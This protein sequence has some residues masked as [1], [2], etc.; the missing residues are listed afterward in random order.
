MLLVL[1]RL[2]CRSLSAHKTISTASNHGRPWL[3]LNNVKAASTE[4]SL[5]ASD[6]IAL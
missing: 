3:D 5:P 4:V 6:T 2:N 1:K